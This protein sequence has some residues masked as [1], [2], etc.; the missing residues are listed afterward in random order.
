MWVCLAIM[1]VGDIIRLKAHVALTELPLLI[2]LFYHFQHDTLRLAAIALIIPFAL[3]FIGF[4]RR[5]IAL[6]DL[7]ALGMVGVVMGWPFGL[8]T[9]LL[10]K[11]SFW[12]LGIV[13]IVRLISRDR[14]GGYYVFPYVVAIVAG[15]VLTRYLFGH[16]PG[17]EFFL[18]SLHP[19]NLLGNHMA[20]EIMNPISKV[21]SQ[22]R[23][24]FLSRMGEYLSHFHGGIK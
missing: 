22:L 18:S 16:F 6:Y 7:L 14:G 4:V 3:H 5:R 2:G 1:M 8:L 9:V 10:A 13:G 24:D 17:V 11:F 19:E 15:A 12:F 23:W 21:T 20:L